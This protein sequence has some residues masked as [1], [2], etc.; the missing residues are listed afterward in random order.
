MPDISMC[1]AENCPVA[2]QCY[3]NAAS[4]TVPDD[5]QS[6]MRFEPELGEKCCGFWPVK[7]E[8]QGD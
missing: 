4:G 6:Y 5:M 2:E 7:P 8:R 1:A 3:R